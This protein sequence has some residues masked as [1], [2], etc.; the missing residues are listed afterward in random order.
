VVERIQDALEEIS[1]QYSDRRVYCCE[2]QVATLEGHRVKLAGGVLDADLLEKITTAL[3]ERF[4]E[5]EFDASGVKILR[6][7]RYLTVATNVTGLYAEPSFRS[8]MVSQLLDG[9]AVE[10]LKQ[11]KDWVQVRQDDGYLGWTYRPY[12]VETVAPE[13]TH[14]VCEPISLMHTDPDASAQVI[15]RIVAGTAVRV[16]AQVRAWSRLVLASGLVGWVLREH[17]RGLEGMLDNAAERR[18]Q[19]VADGARLMGVPY[20]WGGCTPLGIDCSGFAQLLHRL[21]GVSIPRD[22]DMEFGEGQP[23][24]PPFE[25]GDLLFFGGEGGKRSITHVGMSLGGW[26]IVHSSRNR[27]GVYQDDVQ[28]VP[29]LRDRFVGARTFME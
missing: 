22:A 26:R 27:N 16:E 7:G 10:W 29:H 12:L 6:P 28:A 23:V 18:Q 5:V 25:P 9:F 2:L 14:I 13:P 11:E 17:L 15:G 21:A 20:V 24:E 19:M 8:E 1:K 3:T 4:P